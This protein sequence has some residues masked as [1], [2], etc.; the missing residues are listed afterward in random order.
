V[1]IG[2]PHGHVGYRRRHFLLTMVVMLSTLGGLAVLVTVLREP[3][4]EPVISV[5]V[6]VRI[7]GWIVV[8]SACV[9]GT[10]ADRQIG[11]RVRA[12]MPFFEEGARIELVTTGAYAIVRHPIYAAGLWFQL[13][14]FLATGYLAISRRKPRALTAGVR[15][16]RCASACCSYY[17]WAVATNHASK[18]H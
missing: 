16:T 7:A 14:V 10:V 11:I 15:C 9:L 4:L 17:W 12:F 13:G 8:A 6:A 1:G 3:I 18:H 2:G 5:P